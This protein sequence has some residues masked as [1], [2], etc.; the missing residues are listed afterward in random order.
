MKAKTNGHNQSSVRISNR[1]LV[2]DLLRKNDAMTVSQISKEVRLSKT[3][4]WK[5]IDYF[6]SLNL[7]TLIGKAEA[8]DEGG[9]KPE[10]YR[11]N[12]NCGYVITASFLGDAIHLALTDARASIFYKEIVHIT[13]DE[14]LENIIII[15]SDFIRKWQEPGSLVK[16]EA[17]LVGIAIAASGVVDPES[18]MSITASRFNSWRTFSPIQKMIEEKVELQAPFYIDNYNRFHIYAEKSIGQVKDKDNIILVNLN[19]DGVGGAIIADSKLKRGP[20]FLT[21]ELGHM[22]LNPEDTEICHCGGRGCFEQ[23]VSIPRFLNTARKEISEHPE[24]GL[25]EKGLT[26]KRIFQASN[27]GDTL[28][29]DLLDSILKWFSIA[30]YNANL[31]FNAETIIISGDYRVAG[32]YFYSRLSDLVENRGFLKIAK[33]FD[34]RYSVFDEEGSLRGGACY[35]LNDYFA[36]NSDY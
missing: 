33:N 23:L 32:D 30:L 24:T 36:K 6:L 10:L 26:L 29:Q 34:I 25:S 17:K 16:K 8:S 9:K 1:S 4:I 18:G 7:V 5:I 28:A 31:V 12:E 27:E 35:A 21:G 15:I 14:K 11:F 19:A 2:L 20:R 22:C 3:T 13:N